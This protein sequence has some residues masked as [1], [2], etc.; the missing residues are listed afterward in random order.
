[1]ACTPS[2]D[3][4]QEEKLMFDEE[5]AQFIVVSEGYDVV[6]QPLKAIT[7]D[8]STGEVNDYW[9]VERFRDYTFK[10]CLND[11]NE[12]RK[13]RNQ[14]FLVNSFQGT[15]E[16]ITGEDGC[17]RWTEAIEY[18]YFAD[19]KYILL[20]RKLQG[21][22][23]Y[24]GT[25][26]LK[27]AVNPWSGRDK[28]K[29]E[30]VFLKPLRGAV[31]RSVLIEGDEEIFK[32]LWGEGQRK[33]LSLD[34]V[35]IQLT[36]KGT[37]SKSI[38]KFSLWL[39]Q[40]TLYVNVFNIKGE[41]KLISIKNGGHFRVFTR[42]LQYNSINGN[43]DSLDHALH[44]P[45]PRVVLNSQ[46]RIRHSTDRQTTVGSE[47][48]MQIE[49]D[50]AQNWGNEQGWVALRIQ[51]LD[52]P[53]GPFFKTF[54]AIYDVGLLTS[55]H[56]GKNAKRKPEESEKY[57]KEMANG[58]SA[59]DNIF[60]SYKVQN[61]QFIVNRP[62]ST[63]NSLH[64]QGTSF[65]KYDFSYMR[66]QFEEVKRGESATTR[67]I[68]FRVQTCLRKKTNG[69]RPTLGSQFQ[70]TIKERH[71]QREKT[72]D[73]SAEGDNR[74]LNFVH[75]LWF[76]QF[77]PERLFFFDFDIKEVASNKIVGR[78]GFVLNPWDATWTFGRDKRNLS[79][80]YIDEVNETEKIR[81]RFFIPEFAYQ[82]LRFRY[83]IDK[84]L[85]LRVK[86]SVLLSLYPRMLRYNSRREGRFGIYKLRD[87]IYLMK[88]ALEKQYLDPAT[89]AQVVKSKEEN[90]R[91]HELLMR[92]GDM[93]KKHHISIVK[94]L[95]R[96]IDGRI[97][98][99]VEFNVKDL[100]IMRI[101]A[102]MMVQL[103]PIEEWRHHMVKLYDNFYERQVQDIRK[104]N[105]Y[106]NWESFEI[107]QNEKISNIR[108]IIS[109]M[110]KNERMVHWF[111]ENKSDRERESNKLYKIKNKS[112]KG[113]YGI[114]EVS[115]KDMFDLFKLTHPKLK[116]YMGV[117]SPLS[118]R[119]REVL[120]TSKVHQTDTGDICYIP[121]NVV[122]PLILN[123]FVNVSLSPI[124][125][126]DL[127]EFI[128]SPESSGLE[129]ETFFGPVTM[130]LNGN[131]SN[132]R[133]TRNITEFTCETIDCDQLKAED[134]FEEIKNKW[135][136]TID[137]KLSQH[138]L[139]RV[140]DHSKYFNS[141]RYLNDIQV[142]DLIE[143]LEEEEREHRVLQ[144]AFS[145]INNYLELYNFSFLSL[146]D[147]DLYKVNTS[148][149]EGRL[150]V[151]SDIT[152][153]LEIDNQRR[154]KW[155]YFVQG[156]AQKDTQGDAQE[157]TQVNDSVVKNDMKNLIQSLR[158]SES[159]AKR[160]CNHFASRFKNKNK[161]IENIRKNMSIPLNPM[162]N[163]IHI[164]DQDI[165]DQNNDEFNEMDDG[166]EIYRS[167]SVKIYK[168][169]MEQFKL[170]NDQFNQC[171][172]VYGESPDRKIC[173]N[174]ERS[175]NRSGLLNIERKLRVKK[176]GRY[177]S[178][179]GKS[180]NLNV[181]A[182]FSLQ[183]SESFSESLSGGLGAGGLKTILKFGKSGN[184]F[185]KGG[186]G[187]FRLGMGLFRD[188]P[189]AGGL[190][191]TF[192][193][194]YKLSE[195]E[196]N[197]FS[198]GTSINENTFLVMQDATMDIELLDYT[199]CIAISFNM[200]QLQEDS[201]QSDLEKEVQYKMEL[202]HQT[203][204]SKSRS[205]AEKQNLKFKYL[206]ELT[207][208][209]FICD[210]QESKKNSSQSPSSLAIREKYYYFTQHFTEGDMLDPADLY[211]HPWLLFIRGKTDVWRF[212][213][214]IKA[215]DTKL[216]DS[217]QPM[218]P[219]VKVDGWPI[220]KL[221]AA[222][223]GVIP[224]FPGIYTMLHNEDEYA[225]DFPW[226]DQP[227]NSFTQRFMESLSGGS[228]DK[229]KP[230]HFMDKRVEALKDP[231]YYDKRHG[232]TPS[233]FDVVTASSFNSNSE[234]MPLMEFDSD[235]QQAAMYQAGGRR[236]AAS[237]VAQYLAIASFEEGRAVQDLF[238]RELPT[239]EGEYTVLVGG[240][241]NNL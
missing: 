199:K 60:Q 233:I 198:D 146:V 190:I 74:C 67:G 132:M 191:D 43:I 120:D 195:S 185:M 184:S 71:S 196:S 213:D 119:D 173:E 68:R 152:P 212:L 219:V 27:I 224:S 180:Q 202:S 83:S 134:V 177:F 187:K 216:S 69:V 115:W 179:G 201:Y 73:V 76:K 155:E 29:S 227:A 90:A 121:Y 194:D 205:E 113:C 137:A 20:E 186:V 143:E 231:D 148:L 123:D 139:D 236:G 2:K 75:E 81:S 38:N 225:V 141:M 218:G 80:N 163:L 193:F 11:R 204:Q 44:K 237:S 136:L 117:G 162:M 159:L 164:H 51:P 135:E 181:G 48:S 62:M 79:K 22:G 203:S 106:L 15:K 49:K 214:R 31:S 30:V 142:D 206:L 166:N 230:M 111:I 220:Q 23:S 40:G 96:V 107:L 170:S 86:K 84:Y 56:G 7:E 169:C 53:F 99:P 112:Y 13:L 124:V 122:K 10:V 17:F 189:F 37:A 127:D 126:L 131:G 12:S 200:A 41:E 101:R 165:H 215:Q 93:R 97:I 110:S 158:M 109:E 168:E 46:D 129:R 78:E 182:S 175:K 16:S 82:T 178:K 104:S 228:L 77:K 157:D 91:S 197:S 176:T 6:P 36:E 66:P 14:K 47:L 9:R 241:C 172:V 221:V 61:S 125:G 130:L 209:L 108:K 138:K 116:S 92:S 54:E 95:V 171:R 59:F 105:K 118:Q 128:D 192:A 55:I 1:M 24:R 208:G 28:T 89:H 42:M 33:I 72:Y 70:L 8:K 35:N 64:P 211:N 63:Q 3:M 144:D 174:R 160:I 240:S 156:G 25:F 150:S 87:G 39:K 57:S 19:A 167:S 45:A 5:S 18:N 226:S 4:G 217:F 133:P 239:C 188:V 234:E 85:S 102:Q 183:H 21:L 232:S 100:R 149:C 229:D 207:R 153:C 88:V 114:P 147:E 94:R 50:M 26:K 154:I 52:F 65:A 58:L 98:T 161:R 34:K 238:Y 151:L 32:A 140:Y 210:E 103:Q 222:Y 223:S 235:F 145:Q